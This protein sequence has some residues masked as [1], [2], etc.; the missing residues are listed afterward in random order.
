MPVGEES[1]W[2]VG[3]FDGSVR[4]GAVWGR[5]ACDMKGGL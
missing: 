4:D 3:P 5:G 1:L 2:R